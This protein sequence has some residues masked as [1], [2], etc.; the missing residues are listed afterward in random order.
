MFRPLKMQ[1]VLTCVHYVARFLRDTK[2]QLFV[3]AIIQ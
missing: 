3:R 1:L 2:R